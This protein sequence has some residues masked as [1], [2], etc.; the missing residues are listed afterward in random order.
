MHRGHL[1]A[2]FE[3]AA[4]IL[5][6]FRGSCGI[7]ALGLMVMRGLSQSDIR[8]GFLGIGE[9]RKL[10][11]LNLGAQ[12]LK[13]LCRSIDSALHFGI[14]PLEEI[15]LGPSEAR[16]ARADSLQHLKVRRLCALGIFSSD[17]LQQNAC[18]HNG[19]R[20]R[21][22]VI[23][24]WRKWNHTGHAD[25]SIGGFQPYNAAERRWNTDRSSGIGAH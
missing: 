14:H 2:H 3:P 1:R 20:E 7:K 8:R 17:G 15:L 10:Y 16:S 22:G 11:F 9:M 19:A 5:P 24:A 6:V 21:A 13:Y 4:Y 23:K 18:I 25:Q 12:L